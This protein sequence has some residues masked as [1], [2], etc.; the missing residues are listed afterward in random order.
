MTLI[1]ETSRQQGRRGFGPSYFAAASRTGSSIENPAL[2]DLRGIVEPSERDIVTILTLHTAMQYG[3]ISG[4]E[5]SIF[6]LH[7]AALQFFP[8]ANRRPSTTTE[9]TA[10]NLLQL[11][12]RTAASLLHHE[13]LSEQLDTLELPVNLADLLDGFL[14]TALTRDVCLCNTLLANTAVKRKYDSLLNA[15]VQFSGDNFDGVHSLSIAIDCQVSKDW[16]QGC[17]SVLNNDQTVLPF[18]NAIFDK[19]LAP[20]CLRLNEICSD[21]VIPDNVKV[22][23]EL[24]HWHNHRRALALKAPVQKLGKFA[25]RRNDFYMAEMHAYAASLANAAGKI[26]EPETIIVN[27]RLQPS[28]SQRAPILETSDCSHQLEKGGCPKSGKKTS[29]P[30]K[31]SGRTMAL[32]A[33]AAIKAAKTQSRGDVDAAYWKVKCKELRY[34]PNLHRRYLAALNYSMELSYASLFK[35]EVELYTVDCLLRI[36]M[37]RQESMGVDAGRSFAA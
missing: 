35:P 36:W 37:G 7:T 14:L 2:N 27:Q 34:Q 10:Q 24:S 19:H 23:Q 8:L 13:R 18:K 15:L 25:R 3:A 31:K 26:L 28:K 20:V 12:T 11:F 22:F 33:A 16:T 5:A 17:C 32:E 29:K 30:T 9:N 6:L 21:G 4:N 1:L